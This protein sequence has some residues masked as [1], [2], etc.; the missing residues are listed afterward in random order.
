MLLPHNKDP[1]IDHSQYDLLDLIM[2]SLRRVVEKLVID[3][4]VANERINQLDMK[5]K[6]LT[7]NTNNLQM[8]IYEKE[9][10]KLLCFITT[11]LKNKLC[12]EFRRNDIQ[13]NP[14]DEDFA[15]PEKSIR[16]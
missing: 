10:K 13:M 8:L 5:V 2:K 11:P 15:F 6:N 14:L 12:Q 9:F 1:L 4:C 7:E 16:V 3:N